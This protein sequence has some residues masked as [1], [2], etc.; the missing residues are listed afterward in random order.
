MHQICLR[1]LHADL[2]Q[3]VIELLITEALG[4]VELM[5]VPILREDLL[6]VVLVHAEVH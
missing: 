3:V 4:D 6:D 5:W 1:V 2:L